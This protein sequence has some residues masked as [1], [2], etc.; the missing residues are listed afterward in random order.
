M[1]LSI[2][3]TTTRFDVPAS[4]TRFRRRGSNPREVWRRRIV[5]VAWLI[6]KLE[7]RDALTVDLYH[8]RFGLSVRTFRRDIATLRDAAI[9]IDAD[10]HGRGYRMLYF[11]PDIDAT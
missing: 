11:T 5:R 1:E 10:E 9:S 4:P 3:M 7:R 6:A 8:T 2:E